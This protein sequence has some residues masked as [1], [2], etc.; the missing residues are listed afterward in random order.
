MASYHFDAKIVGRSGGKSAIGAA[1]YR[2][3]ALLTCAETGEV[4]DYRRK[5]G[6]EAA[7]I[8]TPEGAPS[9]ATDRQALWSA[10]QAKE[11]RKNSQLARELVLAL[12]H[13]LDPAA[14]TALVLDWVQEHLV[15]EG[16]VADVAIH[17]PEPRDEQDPRN[18][19]AHILLTLR[20]F[21]PDQA[22]GWAKNKAR[23]WND[24]A[25][26]E[27]WRESWAAAQNTAFANLGL[28]VRVDH[29]TLADQLAE[30]QA[31]GDKIRVL[32]LD[33]DPEPRM[34][35]AA[36]NMEQTA[37]KHGEDVTTEVGDAVRAS[38]EKRAEL[39]AVAA[40][41][42]EAESELFEMELDAM[43]D[44]FTELARAEAEAPSEPTVA[45]APTP[46]VSATD[47]RTRTAVSRQL[48][49]LGLEQFEVSVVGGDRDYVQL[50]TPAEILADL[51]RLKRA[52][53][54]DSSIFVRGPRDRDHDLVLVDDIDAFTPELMERD[55][56]KPAVV[57]Q[58]SPGNYQ[59]WIKLG[60][61]VSADVRREAA[62]ILARQYGGDVAAAD[63][64]Q[65]G[66]LGGFT[67]PKPEYKNALGR[68]PFA[69]LISYFGKAVTAALELLNAARAALAIKKAA[70]AAAAEV[71]A[72]PL[73]D[74]DLVSWW[75][76]SHAAVPAHVSLS[77][78]DWHLTHKALGSGR[79]AED[80]VAALEATADRKKDHAA[81]YA[82]LT[83]QK[84]LAQRKP[85][86]ED[87]GPSFG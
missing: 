33:R 27:Q 50:M 12:P 17:D 70:A 40:N 26:L 43:A 51:P 63:G 14:S 71:T 3:G 52:N 68:S 55:G 74:A 54:A 7:F 10:V 66:R 42:N 81:G 25:L 2:A 35:V 31:A 80:V 65:S 84:A 78:V 73:V 39:E 8:L 46:A 58:T 48:I 60:E 41:L 44:D 75:R 67:N 9:W 83:V 28:D 32:L 87:D 47:D 49:G 19:H 4:F 61:P 18:R 76:A 38:R 23:A 24:V 69:L 72:A 53:A 13:E 16:M 57:V 59:A 36:S 1:A 29:R 11:S 37:R 62:L 64:H 6:I 79:T 77:E 85:T 20:K 82:A 22:D 56:L 45:P 34:G 30:A 15:E 21:D 5:R 86:A